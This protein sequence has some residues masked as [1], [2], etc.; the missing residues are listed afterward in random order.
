MYLFELIYLINSSVEK[1]GFFI[2]ISM[3]KL[4]Y[5]LTLDKSYGF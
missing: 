2:F 4:F 3:W 1:L 5:K